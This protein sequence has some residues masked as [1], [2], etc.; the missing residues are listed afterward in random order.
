MSFSVTGFK[1]AI[2][3]GSRPNLY[4][5][6]VTLPSGV[7]GV[8]QSAITNFNFL[9]RSASLP[10]SAAGLIEIPMLAGRR[11]KRVGDRTFTEWTT[12]VLNDENF[13]IRSNI[14]KWQNEIV[15]VNYELGKIGN[16][17]FTGT[18]SETIYGMV[19]IVQLDSSG[20]DV[21][22][23]FYYLHNCWPSDIAAI[24]LSYDTTDSIEEFTVTWT[25]DYYTVGESSTKSSDK[26]G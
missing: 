3:E 24:D 11:L 9:C 16:R 18:P 21:D 20:S 7:S 17:N 15:K 13:V 6:N 5:V 10:G 22:N 23:G 12:S 19:E 1:T 25:Y 14:E 8:A 26:K 2:G 4:R